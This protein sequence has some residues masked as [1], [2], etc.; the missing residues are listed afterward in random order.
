MSR[1]RW[2]NVFRQL[3]KRDLAALLKQFVSHLVYGRLDPYPAVSTKQYAREEKA[4]QFMLDTFSGK[5]QKYS[6]D[7]ATRVGIL[8][9]NTRKS[10]DIFN[11]LAIFSSSLSR[12]I[13][14]SFL[15]S[16][17]HFVPIFSSF[18]TIV[19]SS[20]LSYYSLNLRMGRR[21]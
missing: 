10:G 8:W 6:C 15:N 2:G 16:S 18:L 11:A 4:L 17:R 7:R 14:L 13:F 12:F 19:I 21:V 1:A 5:L 9:G 3:E 20:Y